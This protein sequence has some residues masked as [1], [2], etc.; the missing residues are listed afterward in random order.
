MT[1]YQKID[2]LGDKQASFVANVILNWHSNPQPKL[3]G[4]LWLLQRGHE[5]RIAQYSI[6]T[7]VIDGFRCRWQDLE[8]PQMLHDASG[9]NARA[10]LNM[11]VQS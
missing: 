9:A 10:I 2:A 6:D 4:L 5:I 11:A 1:H 8:Y 3:K 7:L